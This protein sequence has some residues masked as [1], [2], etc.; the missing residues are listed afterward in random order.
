MEKEN[1][2]NSIA[3][4][5]KGGSVKSE[6]LWE[7][8]EKKYKSSERRYRLLAENVMDVIWT[9]DFDLKFTYISPSIIHMRGYSAEEAIN[10]SLA[11][12][13]TPASCHVLL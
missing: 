1:G 10:Q 6:S 3:I 9:L 13:F 2:S 11:E 4:G 5:L 12:T 8:V 7:N